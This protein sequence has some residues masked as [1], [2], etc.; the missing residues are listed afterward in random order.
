MWCPGRLLAGGHC[1]PFPYCVRCP[2]I[3]ILSTSACDQCLYWDNNFIVASRNGQMGRVW[4]DFL[5]PPLMV[6]RVMQNQKAKN[7][8][9]IRYPALSRIINQMNIH[10]CNESIWSFEDS[11]L[12]TYLPLCLIQIE[13]KYLMMTAIQG[14]HELGRACLYDYL[15]IHMYM[16]EQTITYIILN[17][18]F[19][20]HWFVFI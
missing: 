8:M 2:S 4:L 6:I 16:L 7:L 11:I 12:K 13:R 14:K 19:T 5:M 15:Y 10:W 9:D 1:L 17:C 20:V 18:R 3:V